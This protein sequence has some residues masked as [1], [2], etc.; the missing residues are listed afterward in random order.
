MKELVAEQQAIEREEANS[1]AAKNANQRAMLAL[2][3]GVTVDKLGQI[4]DYHAMGEVEKAIRR[5][6]A[7]HEQ[8]LL[9]KQ[10]PGQAI[11]RWRQE[12]DQLL[13]TVWL[14][15]SP[16]HIKLLWQKV[17][18][19]LDDQPTQLQQEAL[20]IEPVMD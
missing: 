9:A 20:A 5:R 6:Q 12:R 8:E 13:D 17:A 1:V 10:E 2:V 11:L 19:L 16:S 3:R 15:T 4:V 18:E 14:A 7:V